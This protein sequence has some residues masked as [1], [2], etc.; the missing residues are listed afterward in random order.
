MP[1]IINS[2]ELQGFYNLKSIL[3]SY[4]FYV[5]FYDKEI[6]MIQNNELFKRIGPMP[7]I[8]H[9][10]V[11][12]INI[13]MSYNVLKQ[14]SKYGPL[15]RSL[16][17]ID[18]DGFEIVLE[19]EEDS[20]GTI[21]YLI[22]WLQRRIVDTDGTYTAPEIAKLDKIMIAVEDSAGLPVLFLTY[23]N[24]MFFGCDNVTYDYSTN[25]PLSYTLRF[26]ADWMGQ[27][28]PKADFIGQVQGKVAHGLTKP[29]LDLKSKA[30]TNKLSSKGVLGLVK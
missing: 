5:T 9:W 16:P 13:P 23:N 27:V 4:R 21:S 11:K 19:L 22:Q 17:Y 6:F 10:H 15:S 7:V 18:E 26:N 28:T 2:L 29:L 8:Q 3:A 14:V 25:Q 24:I 12:T 1:P 20:L 30:F